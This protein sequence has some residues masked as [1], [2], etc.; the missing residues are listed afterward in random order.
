MTI[1][2][3]FQEHVNGSPSSPGKKSPSKIP[4]LK[5]PAHAAPHAAPHSG[6]SGGRGVV[7]SPNKSATAHTPNTPDSTTSNTSIEKK[8][9]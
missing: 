4:G 2:P 6:G 7:R 5:G 8:S 3:T 1:V 9:E